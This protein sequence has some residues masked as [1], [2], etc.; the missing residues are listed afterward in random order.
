ML[1]EHVRIYLFRSSE[2]LELFRFKM[3]VSEYEK[4]R[5]EAIK[6]RFDQVFDDISNECCYNIVGTPVY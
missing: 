3:L 4:G 2:I 5:E 6:E 1:N